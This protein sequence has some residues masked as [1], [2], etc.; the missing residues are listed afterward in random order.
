[1]PDSRYSPAAERFFRDHAI[2]PGVAWEIGVREKRGELL[3]PNGKRRLLGGPG[4]KHRQPAGQP[5][6]PW[7]VL[8]GE[9]RSILI[10][11][12]ESDALAASSALSTM[13]GLEGGDPS[14]LAVPGTGCPVERVA[15]AAQEAGI[16]LAYIATDA[17]EA[18]NS[19][20]EKLRSAFYPGV[21]ARRVQLSPG[22][23][24]AERL[25]GHALED[26]GMAL[27]D[28]LKSAPC[29]YRETPTGRAIDLGAL[30]ANVQELVER[31]V[32]LPG[33]AE[34]TAIVLWVAHTWAIEGAHATPYLLVISAE[35]RSGKSR[36]LEVLSL[37]V[38]RP[39]P[40]L[41]ISEA[42]LFRKIAK[43]QPTL[44]LDEIDAIFGSAVERTEPLRAVLNAGNRRGASVARCAGKDMTEVHDFPVFCPKLLAGIDTGT[45][46]PDTI[47]DRSIAIRMM[48]R[49][50]SEPVEK[51]RPRLVEPEAAKLKA[52]FEAWA[53]DRALETL[54][55]AEPELPD[56]LDDRQA[57][58][59]EPLLAI[60]DLAGGEWPQRA[61]AAARQLQSEK[62]EDGE[63]LGVLVLRAI[64]EVFEEKATIATQE[65]LEGLNAREELPVGAWRG[66]AG[67]NAQ[68]LRR[69]L[70]PYTIPRPENIRF[71]ATVLRGYRREW[72]EEAWE[73]YAPQEPQQA[74]QPLHLIEGGAEK[75]GAVAD[76]ADVADQ[77]T[78]GVEQLGLDAYPPWIGEFSE[79]DRRVFEAVHD[80]FVRDGSGEWLRGA[81]PPPSRNGAGK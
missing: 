27:A 80:A 66:G 47:R 38:A 49:K 32:V 14:I 23:D 16:E 75:A 57:E 56:E 20:A 28:L 7:T 69:L 46:L 13:P 55:E 45:R 9:G 18:G 53:T 70:R 76:V 41:G 24:L 78:G 67:L 5:L 35:K 50:Q 21:D 31:F 30:L 74:Q 3:Y 10:C 79:A 11:E 37:P 77:T 26:R 15:A 6:E 40:L 33:A 44:L 58:A 39:W 68:G 59:W 48:R 43:E 72:F 25:V 2:Q 8:R 52:E 51:F 60:A 81:P 42:A 54:R 17:D 73:R 65:L 62:S 22:S 29:S 34:A 64:R 61:R 71:G 36:L 12:G 63:S 19:Y 4:P 1:M